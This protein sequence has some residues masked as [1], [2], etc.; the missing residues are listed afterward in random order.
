MDKMSEREN[1][2][3]ADVLNRREEASMKREEGRREEKRG[4]REEREGCFQV[5]RFM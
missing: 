2:C 1:I 3:R 5:G 4:K